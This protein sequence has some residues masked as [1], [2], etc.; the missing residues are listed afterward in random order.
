MCDLAGWEPAGG[1]RT[2]EDQGEKQGNNKGKQVRRAR[3]DRHAQGKEQRI[4][5]LD[6][7]L[8]RCVTE[9]NRATRAVARAAASKQRNNEIPNLETAET[10]MG[11]TLW[12]EWT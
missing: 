12:T 4:T 7:A 10:R 1:Q 8:Q 5:T 9:T 11:W 3:R 6:T 2:R